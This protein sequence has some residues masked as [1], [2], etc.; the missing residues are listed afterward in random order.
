MLRRLL[1]MWSTDRL[2]PDIPLTHAMLFSR[3]LGDWICR[4]KFKSFG[5][6]S[7]F[8]PQ[9][10]AVCT[11]RISVGRNVTIRTGC[12][13]FA[14]EVDPGT[15]VIEDNVLIASGVHIYCDN[16]EFSDISR[17]ICDQGYRAPRPVLICKGAWIGAKAIILPGVTI[18]RNA[19]VG[20]GSV[21]VRSIPD[22]SLAVG[23]PARV[24]KRLDQADPR[25]G[26]KV[27]T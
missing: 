14:G 26:S 11:S 27:S 22:F 3:R 10:Y 23:N 17:P 21:V 9:A 1:W 5:D 2:G 18:G 8:R 16:H 20:A 6:G 19:V 25:T 15:I 7:R 12:M 4:K 24:I 13:F